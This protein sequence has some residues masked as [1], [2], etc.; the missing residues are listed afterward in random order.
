MSN[1][2]RWK[3]KDMEN[4]CGK[5]SLL[6]REGYPARDTELC[7]EHWQVMEDAVATGDPRD[8]LRAWVNMNGGAKSL[9]KRMLG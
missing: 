8:A 2:C 6:F 5:P 7:R 3:S 9:T 1:L 4:E